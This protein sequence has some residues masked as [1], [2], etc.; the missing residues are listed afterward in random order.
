MGLF[1]ESF[2]TTVSVFGSLDIVINNAGIMNDRFWELEVDINLVSRI[3]IYIYYYFVLFLHA[4]M[5]TL[6][7]FH[8]LLLV[9]VQC[10]PSSWKGLRTEKNDSRSV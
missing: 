9:C 10:S 2:Q 6:V 5:C 3:L 7:E 8:E 1:T 4:L